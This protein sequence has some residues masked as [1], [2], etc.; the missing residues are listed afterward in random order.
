MKMLPVQ[1]GTS[2]QNSATPHILLISALSAHLIAQLTPCRQLISK[3]RLSL[4]WPQKAQPPIQAPRSEK[5]RLSSLVYSSPFN[6]ESSALSWTFPVI[7]AFA[8]A[9][10]PAAPNLLHKAARRLLP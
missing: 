4:A 9:G 2:V 1:T 7:Y 6:F 5:I 8:P 3:Q 10:L